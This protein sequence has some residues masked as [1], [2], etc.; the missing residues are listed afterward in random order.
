LVSSRA[1]RT[2]ARRCASPQPMTRALTDS[3][4]VNTGSRRPRAAR[5]VV[6]FFCTAVHAHA[7][8]SHGRV[9]LFPRTMVRMSMLEPPGAWSR[10][11]VLR[12]GAVHRIARWHRLTRGHVPREGRPATVATPTSSRRISRPATAS[13]DVVPDEPTFL[14]GSDTAHHV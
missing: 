6:V 3:V 10:S 9:I 1:A 7:R 14:P 5:R 8:P 11:A 4:T 12:A 13:D 2:P